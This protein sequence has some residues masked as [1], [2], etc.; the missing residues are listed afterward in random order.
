MH[1]PPEP[2]ADGV[3]I[4]V[5]GSTV[6]IPVQLALHVPP[7]AAQLAVTVAPPTHKSEVPVMAVGVFSTAML[8]VAG[9]VQP[10]IE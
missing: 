2:V 7:E 8:N 4:P 9:A 6:A 3:M 1:V 10:G 5:V